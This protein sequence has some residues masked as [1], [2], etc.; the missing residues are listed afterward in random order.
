MTKRIAPWVDQS[1]KNDTKAVDILV[2][3]SRVKIMNTTINKT[4]I[5]ESEQR[6]LNTVGSGLGAGVTLRDHT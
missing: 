2:E 3:N 6:F 4:V 5:G 1:S